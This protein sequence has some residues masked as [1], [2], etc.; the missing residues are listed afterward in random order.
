MK[1]VLSFDIEEWFHAEIFGNRF[2][3]SLWNGLE[4]RVKIGT[5]IILNFLSK[6][7]VKATFFFLG[8]VAEKYPEIVK[9]TSDEGHEIGSHGYNHIRIDKLSPPGFRDEVKK[10]VELLRSISGKKILGYRA[11]TFS[12]TKETLWA[13][14]IL[15]EEG[16]K[17]DSSVFPIYH[18][19][20]GIPDA[21]LT[22]YIAYRNDR[23]SIVEFPMPTVQIGKYNLP[24]GG[25]GYFRLYPLWLSMKFMEK[26]QLNDR[27]VIFYAHPWEFDRGIPK[28]DLKLFE[29]I[30]HY[31]GNHKILDRLDSLISSF[32]FTSFEKSSLWE[33][34]K[35][36]NE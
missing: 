15:L 32:D 1:N 11:P 33:S 24:F 12:I 21:P 26:C 9:I 31:H 8:W 17:Y 6:K 30:R 4:S 19:R 36:S 14:P 7:N 27:P 35:E 20:Y 34:M 22:P 28:I 16:Y 13:L 18:D 2:P 3:K 23:N 10:S 29:T 25:G 5:E